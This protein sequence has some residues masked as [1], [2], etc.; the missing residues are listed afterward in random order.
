MDDIDIMIPAVIQFHL[1][2]CTDDSTPVFLVEYRRRTPFT[3]LVGKHNLQIYHVCVTYLKIKRL[4]NYL[5]PPFYS[6]FYNKQGNLNYQLF[7]LLEA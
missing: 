1:I 3:E 4:V 5:P 2:D 6:I 7:V